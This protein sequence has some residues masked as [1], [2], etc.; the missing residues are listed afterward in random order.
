MENQTPTRTSTDPEKTAARRI[1]AFRAE[2]GLTLRELGAKS[3]LSDA[4]LSRLENGRTGVTLASLARLAD[5]FGTTINA[6]FAEAEQPVPI[7]VCRAG[8]GAPYRFRGNRGS[9]TE[10]LAHGKGNKQMEPLIVDV[11]T[12]KGEVPLKAHAGE[13][14]N[15]VLQG[16]CRFFFG[17][18]SYELSAGDSVYFDATV[19][20]AVRPLDRKPCRLLVVVTSADLR[21]HDHIGKVLEGRIQA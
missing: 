12:S 1:A 7:V 15:Y 10:L 5:V 19:E 16:R 14:F 8:E 13:E 18:E 6:F 11:G 20:H 21:A 3:G 9:L 2:A 17:A 4:Y